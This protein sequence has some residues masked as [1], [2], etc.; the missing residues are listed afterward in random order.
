MH[1]SKLSK[2]RLAA[3]IVV[4]A[5]TFFCLDGLI[6]RSGLYERHL[7][8]VSMSGY[9]Y[10]IDYY[11]K[12][13]AS[14]PSRDVLLTGDSRMAEGFSAYLANASGDAKNL[15]FVQ[16]SIP[17][18][19]LRTWY[20]LLKDMDPHA[21][22]YRA[23]VI[24]V[25]SYR[26]VSPADPSLDKSMQ[27]T[28]LLAPILG[29]REMVDLAGTYPSTET[30]WQVW[31]RVFI[32]ALNYRMDLQDYLLHP[33]NRKLSVRWR[34]DVNI[35]IGDDYKGHLES[36]DGL[37]VDLQARSLTLPSRLS[38]NE[39]QI[40]TQRFLAPYSFPADAFDAYTQEWL[41]KI[42]ALYAHSNTQLLIARV[43]TSPLPVVFDEKDKPMAHFVAALAGVPNMKLIPEDT[44]LNLENP[45]YFFDTNHLNAEGRVQFTHEMVAVL[46][47]MLTDKAEDHGVTQNSANSTA[48]AGHPSTN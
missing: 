41:E 12:R 45:H 30:K 40:V 4:G 17:G 29:F 11:E 47:T 34:H 24:S 23:I 7:S 6:F 15:H 26:Q 19:S 33:K 46:P 10:Y 3:L 21:D 37:S 38:D 44:F 35:R 27:D 1:D 43:P 32:A 42:C 48:Q 36:M 5:V 31:P 16:G 13:R 18:A 14:D 39:K 22:R 25:P 28:D 2:K 8:P 9:G 20:Y